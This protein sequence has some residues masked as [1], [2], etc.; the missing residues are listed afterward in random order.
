VREFWYG[1]RFIV[2]AAGNHGKPE[3]WK[4]LGWWWQETHVDIPEYESFIKTENQLNMLWGSGIYLCGESITFLSHCKY[5]LI[6]GGFSTYVPEP[7]NIFRRIASKVLL[8]AEWQKV[9]SVESLTLYDKRLK[10]R[11]L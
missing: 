4:D 3:F 7:V 5:R 10:E 9:D 11:F 1:F 8:G 6:W 2:S